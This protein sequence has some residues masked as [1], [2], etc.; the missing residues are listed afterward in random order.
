VVSPRDL[1][2]FGERVAGHR[3]EALGM[4]VIARNVR[5]ASGE[6]DIVAEDG[7]DLAFVEVRARRAAPGASAESLQPSK[8][9]RMWRCAMEYCEV[10]GREPECVRIDVMA[11]D[12]PPGGGVARIE[13]L[14]GIEIPDEG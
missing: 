1:G 4:R 7:E 13:H 3:L 6:I 8:L 11:I 9:Q 5:T 10:A 14:K 12:V 2:A